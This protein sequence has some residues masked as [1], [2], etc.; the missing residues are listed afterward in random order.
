MHESVHISLIFAPNGGE[1]WGA[2]KEQ[3]KKGSCCHLRPYISHQIQAESEPP[4][5]TLST[6]NG[7]AVEQRI[8][9]GSEDGDHGH[10]EVSTKIGVK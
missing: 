8:Y 9:Q 2:Y 5:P 4:L 10:Q 6:M 7:A 1:G 3:V